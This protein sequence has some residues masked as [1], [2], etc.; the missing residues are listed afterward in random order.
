[1]TVRLITTTQSFVGLSV[2]DKPT[3][4]V[5]VGSTFLETDTSDVYI[6]SADGWSFYMD[7]VRGETI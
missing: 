2:D 7:I 3:V 5:S 6:Y 4:G 1:M